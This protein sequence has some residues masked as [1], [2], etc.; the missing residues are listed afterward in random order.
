MQE[1][2]SRFKFANIKDV[3]PVGKTKKVYDLKFKTKEDLLK[4]AQIKDH[5]FKGDN[6]YLRTSNKNNREDPG[7]H[8]N[9]KHRKY[10]NFKGTNLQEGP[11]KFSYKE[12][13]MKQEESLPTE[14]PEPKPSWKPKEEKKQGPKTSNKNPYSNLANDDEEEED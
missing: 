9:Q 14:D 12:V 2:I 10:S 1:I 3:I 7:H 13:K 5:N 6:F 4:A 8:F 11:R